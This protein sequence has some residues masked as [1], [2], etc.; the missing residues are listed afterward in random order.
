[1]TSYFDVCVL[2]VSQCSTD[3]VKLVTVEQ[4]CRVLT[5]TIFRECNSVVGNIYTQQSQLKLGK[6]IAMWSLLLLLTLFLLISLS[7]SGGP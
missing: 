1:M 7:V 5:S 2:V 3:M 4:S 6:Y